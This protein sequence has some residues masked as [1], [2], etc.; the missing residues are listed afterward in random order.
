[1]LRTVLPILF[2]AV[3]LFSQARENN[4]YISYKFISTDRYEVKF[5]LFRNCSGL[6]A[7]NTQTITVASGSGC[8][9]NVSLVVTRDAIINRTPRCSSS[10]ACIPQN[11]PSTSGFEEHIYSG[12]MDLDSADFSD[13]K[14]SSCCDI[15]F[16]KSGGLRPNNISTGIGGL[17]YNFAFLD[18]CVGNN[19]SVVYSNLYPLR[20]YCNYT[21][22]Y[23]PFAFDADG[24]SLVFSLDTPLINNRTTNATYNAPLSAQIPMTPVCVTQTVSCVPA[25]TSGI[26]VGFDFDE[27]SNNIRYT[28]R[29]CSE[30]SVFVNETKEYRKDS[31]GI[32]Q[33]IGITRKEHQITTETISNNLIP[34]ILLSGEYY[35]CVGDTFRL[36]INSSDDAPIGGIADSTFMFWENN[37]PNMDISKVA[38][39]KNEG[40]FITWA[41]ETSNI[42]EDPYLLYIGLTESNCDNNTLVSKATSFYVVDS[43][44]ASPVLTD[45]KNGTLRL[46]SNINGGSPLLTNQVQWTVS[47]NFNFTNPIFRNTD[48]AVIPKLEP[49]KYYVQLVVTNESNC[50][51]FF[52]DSV[53]IDPYFRFDFENVQNVYCAGNTTLLEPNL[54]DAKRPI[55]YQW[56][57]RGNPTVIS[58]DSVLNRVVTGNEI[59]ELN[60]TDANNQNFS[61]QVSIIS[62]PLPNLSTVINPGRKC[63]ESGRFDLYEDAPIGVNVAQNTKDSC[64][65]SFVMVNPKRS[66]MVKTGIGAPYW[67]NAQDFYDSAK[68]QNYIPASGQDSIYLIALNTLT[69]C[70]DS[71]LVIVTIDPE[72]TIETKNIERC[73]NLGSF[74]PNNLLLITPTA[75][76]LVDANYSWSIDSAPGGL[77]AMDLS[78]ILRDEDQ[79]STRQDYKFYPFIPGSDPDAIFNEN[80]I[81]KYKLRFCFTDPVTNCTSCEFVYLDILQ[82]PKNEIEP[83][84]N[85]CYDEGIIELDSNA[86]LAGGSWSLLSFDEQRNGA[87]YNA[88]SQRILNAKQ[89]ILDGSEVEG[90][91]Y[92]LRY[93]NSNA[94][95]LVIDSI[96]I[97]VGAQPNLVLNTYADSIYKDESIS[98]EVIE[99]TNWNLKWENGNI[100]SKRLIRE[101]VLSAGEYNYTMNA[102]NPATSCVHIDTVVITVFK[103][104]RVG[105]ENIFAQELKV[106][107]NPTN[108]IVYFEHSKELL[109][110]DLYSLNG[111]LLLEMEISNDHKSSIDMGILKSGIYL[112]YISGKEGSTVVKI[113]LIK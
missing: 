10:A 40:A 83:F 101:F 2:F 58:T 36:N 86:D 54:K 84:S 35:V 3:S 106:Y 60:A 29:N 26:Y 4:N 32:Y 111:E 63:T 48:S 76:Q 9:T 21:F 43:L 100:N 67:F 68:N 108:S 46:K 5:H 45:L 73:Q 95:C 56:F 47:N 82:A 23:N 42:K 7:P 41:P 57:V 24:D 25:L 79:S 96:E 109:S 12:I 16:E 13:I 15:Y 53:E 97:E 50:S 92:L 49:G 22:E 89:L 69:N 52:R 18:R 75:S 94:Q 19:N 44:S 61:T 72:P 55:A 28:P 80:R 88:A 31:M 27:N 1:M 103:S 90:G 70:I 85:I 71:A 99:G 17:G 112:M 14:N 104:E 59:F 91:A 11:T 107:P 20:A 77:S 93:E 64:D 30:I 39:S 87:E 98:L 65:I 81:G 105:V 6:S 62:N 33:L 38:T 110:A 113:E 37:I 74:S 8:F 51:V 66:G 102:T 34:E 78:N